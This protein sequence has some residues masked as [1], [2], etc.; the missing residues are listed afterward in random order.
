[1][2]ITINLW[3]NMKKLNGN[4]Y[5]KIEEAEKE[6]DS[7]KK[8]FHSSYHKTIP[9]RIKYIDLDFAEKVQDESK[10]LILS[11]NYL[12]GYGELYTSV[13]AIIQKIMERF[14]DHSM[15]DNNLFFMQYDLTD[16]E[17]K[18]KRL[19]Y[20]NFLINVFYEE[21]IDKLKKLT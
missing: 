10:N 3:L 9:K 14:R 11:L 4:F 15:C 20:E 21:C 18:K 7:V 8:L 13:K 12:Y 2:Q 6:I 1:M 5:L 17:R 16:T 19:M